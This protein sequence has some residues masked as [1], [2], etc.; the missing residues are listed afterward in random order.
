M[1]AHHLC[2][3]IFSLASSSL[4]FGSIVVSNDDYLVTCRCRDDM[5]A[6]VMLMFEEPSHQPCS[7]LPNE[8]RSSPTLHSRIVAHLV[9][10]GFQVSSYFRILPSASEFTL[11][12][13]KRLDREEL[14]DTVQVCCDRRRVVCRFE[15]K[16]VFQVPLD[17]SGRDGGGRGRGGSEPMRHLF[18]KVAIL[19]TDEN[20]HAPEFPSNE[21]VVRIRESAKPGTKFPLRPAVDLD[22]EP[23]SVK[24]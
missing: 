13:Q 23:Y 4:I 3:L 17:S 19:L 22:S 8:L 16:V 24:A 14:C 10:P 5:R 6:G 7:L 1:P 20:D 2:L 21:Q 15:L 18:R 11:A 12:T 9:L